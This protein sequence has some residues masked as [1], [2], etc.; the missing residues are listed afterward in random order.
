MFCGTSLVV[1]EGAA[2]SGDADAPVETTGLGADGVDD[3]APRK[4]WRKES[5]W[6]AEVQDEFSS[7]VAS[8]SAKEVAAA[9][10]LPVLLGGSSAGDVVKGFVAVIIDSFDSREEVCN[11]G[12]ISFS[13]LKSVVREAAG[14]REF[15]TS[16]SFRRC[17]TLPRGKSA[18]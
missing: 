10:V 18:A 15:G 3:A 9:D 16:S 5:C 12:A 6:T 13:R 7:T 8:W 14:S 17:K 4:Y 2:G 11:P 1:I